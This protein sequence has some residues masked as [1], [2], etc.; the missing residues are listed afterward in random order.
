MLTYQTSNMRRIS[1]LLA[2]V[3]VLCVKALDYPENNL[4]DHQG[5]PEKASSFGT[6]GHDGIK[7]DKSPLKTIDHQLGADGL[8]NDGGITDYSGISSKDLI[9]HHHKGE[10]LDKE[11][12]EDKDHNA[13]CEENERHRPSRRFTHCEEEVVAVTLMPLQQITCL[14]NKT[15]D[16][17]EAYKSEGIR[18]VE[19]KSKF[20]HSGSISR[21]AYETQCGC[22]CLGQVFEGCGEGRESF[23]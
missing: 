16:R 5:I 9:C 14:Q 17:A 18:C 3:G 15:L 20:A 8:G 1:I 7:N 6:L 23:Q 12:N 13:W 10:L 19:E 4:K 2:V 22:D 21:N 11:I